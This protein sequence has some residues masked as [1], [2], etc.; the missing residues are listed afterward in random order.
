MPHIDDL[1]DSPYLKAGNLQADGDEVTISDIQ[2]QNIGPENKP[3]PV[4][5]VKEF[6]R[7][8]ILN[9]TNSNFIHT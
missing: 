6:D 2:K 4:V 8:L 5:Y 3:K 7:P 1:F 9:K